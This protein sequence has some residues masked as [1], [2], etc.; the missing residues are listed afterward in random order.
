MAG[1]QHALTVGSKLNITGLSEA[2]PAGVGLQ[3]GRSAE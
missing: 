1:R 2:V 3:V